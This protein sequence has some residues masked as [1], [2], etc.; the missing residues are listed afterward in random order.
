[1]DKKNYKNIFDAV[2]THTGKDGEMLGDVSMANCSGSLCLSKIS[3]CLSGWGLYL[4]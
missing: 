2:K 1:M 3:K 4:L